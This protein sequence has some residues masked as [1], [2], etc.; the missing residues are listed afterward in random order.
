MPTTSSGLLRL[1]CGIETFDI[2]YSSRPLAIIEPRLKNLLSTNDMSK[3]IIYSNRRVK[4]EAIH[5]KLSLWLDTNNFILVDNISLVATLTL[6]QKA[7]H[8]KAFV[9]SEVGSD[10]HPRILSATL[11][12]TNAGIDS[13]QVFGVFRVDFPPIIVE[14]KQEGGRA[15]RQPD[16]LIVQDCYCVMISL[17]GFLHHFLRILNPNETVQDLSYR[18]KLL[19][20]L[21]STLRFLVLPPGCFHDYFERQFSSPFWSGPLL[22]D[23]CLNRC[24]FCNGSYNYM[25]PRLDHRGVVQVFFGLFIVGPSVILDLRR[26]ETVINSLKAMQHSA[27]LTFGT[28]SDKPPAPILVKKLLLMLMAAGI[29]ECQHVL[30]PSNSDVKA[31]EYD[32]ALGPLATIGPDGTTPQAPKQVCAVPF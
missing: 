17:E 13:P 20:N 19:D 27:R 32:L 7:H 16:S 25:F 22:S 15:G 4:I 31:E 23:P 5:S 1:V 18:T 11:G 21:L 3:Y 30:V 10:F 14:M 26:I 24:S 9:N 2:C 29:L 28:N 12:A 8:I 6:E